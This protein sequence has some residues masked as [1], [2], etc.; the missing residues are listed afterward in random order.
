M[1]DEPTEQT[2][3]TDEELV[4]ALAQAMLQIAQSVVASGQEPALVLKCMSRALIE[5]DRL[6]A[7]EQHRELQAA[8]A[9]GKALVA[10]DMLLDALGMMRVQ[11]PERLDGYTLDEPF[12]QMLGTVRAAVQS[13]WQMLTE[14]TNPASRLILPGRNGH[15]H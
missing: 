5:L 13:H 2:G 15:G 12:G 1:T 8:P 3:P 11:T 9:H 7:V 10:L 4:D 14:K 6:A